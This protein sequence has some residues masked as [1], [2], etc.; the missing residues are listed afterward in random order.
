MEIRSPV[1]SLPLS[2][3]LSDVTFSDP[4]HPGNDTIPAGG[5][6]ESKR[7]SSTLEIFP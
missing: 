6:L 2:Y 7:L 1:G 3:G 4:G 5:G